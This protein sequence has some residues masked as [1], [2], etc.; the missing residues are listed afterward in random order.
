MSTVR[1]ATDG[2][3]STLKRA[4]C[5]CVCVHTNEIDPEH[6]SVKKVGDRPIAAVAAPDTAGERP[7]S[8]ESGLLWRLRPRIDSSGPVVVGDRLL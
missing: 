7:G 5:V 6:A 4:L 8:T 3:I 2:K 1:P